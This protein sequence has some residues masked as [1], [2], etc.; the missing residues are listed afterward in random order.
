MNQ[1]K[2]TKESTII[3]N[4]WINQNYTQWRYF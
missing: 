2:P 3:R 1:S 4:K